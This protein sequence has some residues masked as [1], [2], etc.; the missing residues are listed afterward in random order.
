MSHYVSQ[1][2][3]GNGF[4]PDTKGGSK[5]SWTLLVKT[6]SPLSATVF[7]L[8]SY[9]PVG[10]WLVGLVQPAW[11]QKTESCLDGVASIPHSTVKSMQS[12]VC[13]TSHIVKSMQN[14]PH[15]QKDATPGETKLK[16][17]TS[18]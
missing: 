5:N 18:D 1:L 10:G 14:Q 9:N 2:K 3:N 11:L 7:A 13:N 6:M 15:S 16:T 17:K 12:I 4:F 8:Y